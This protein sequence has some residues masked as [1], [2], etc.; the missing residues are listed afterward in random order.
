MLSSTLIGVTTL[1]QEIFTLVQVCGRHLAYITTPPAQ[2]VGLGGQGLYEVDH[3]VA[4][5]GHLVSVTTRRVEL[6]DLGAEGY[7][8]LGAPAQLLL[9]LPGLLLPAKHKHAGHR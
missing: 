1:V 6:L 4:S 3:L 5:V 7:E 9:S 2:G 8:V